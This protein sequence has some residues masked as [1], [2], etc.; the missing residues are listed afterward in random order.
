[1]FTRGSGLFVNCL[2]LLRNQFRSCAKLRLADRQY[3]QTDPI[4]LAGG[5][6]TYV[7]LGENPINR[8]DPTG[9]ICLRQPQ[10]QTGPSGSAD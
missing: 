2:G 3:V 7:Y 9:L 6:N 5:I 8:V 1:M 4:G 10:R